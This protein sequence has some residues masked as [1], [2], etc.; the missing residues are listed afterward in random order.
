MVQILRLA[1]SVELTHRVI[2]AATAYTI[3]RM[4]I[5][6]RIPGNP[7]GIAR[8][9]VGD[10]IALGALNLPSRP[11]MAVWDSA[12]GRR[13]RSNRWCNAIAS[14]DSEPGWKLPPVTMIHPWDGTGAPRVLP[15]W[16]HAALIG[17]CEPH[18]PAPIGISVEP[19]KT[20]ADVEDFLTAYVA[21]W[22][23][24][25]AIHEQ[26]K[27]NVRPWLAGRAG[28]FTAIWSGSG[29][30]FCFCEQS[31]RRWSRSAHHNARVP[32]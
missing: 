4:R 22:G 21:G 13:V 20:T 31:G 5:V 7:V 28:R 10:A 19:V 2:E 6:E 30:G 12:S 17:E 25:N 8:R 24:P 26:F 23:I 27:T 3:S 15:I 14:V 9:K 32:S 1:P 29:C 16:L 11:S 18:V